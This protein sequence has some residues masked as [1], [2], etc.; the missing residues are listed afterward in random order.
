MEKMKIEISELTAEYPKLK[1]YVRKHPDFK[2]ERLT[3]K[4]GEN[5]KTEIYTLHY[6]T[7]YISFRIEETKKIIFQSIRRVKERKIGPI[8]LLGKFYFIR[9]YCK[10]KIKKDSILVLKNLKPNG[11]KF[12][13]KFLNLNKELEKSAD[14]IEK[15]KEIKFD[16]YIFNFKKIEK[17]VDKEWKKIKIDWEDISKE[18]PKL[19]KIIDKY[20]KKYPHLKDKLT[21]GL[22]QKGGKRTKYYSAGNKYISR[23]W[24]IR[25]GEITFT[26]INAEEIPKSGPL[27]ALSAIYY[28]SK[29][30]KDEIDEGKNVHIV[31]MLLTGRGFWSRFL[32]FKN[33]NK[34]IDYIKKN[35]KIKKGFGKVIDIELPFK[36]F[37]NLIN[38][39]W[40]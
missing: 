29:F 13:E 9:K 17:L 10:N 4:K 24:F 26:N 23:K 16:N 33:S 37:E 22:D 39:E 36:K 2:D 3:I 40:K 20:S 31:N 30:D 27:L 14:K 35:G 11:K 5:K 25:G 6:K 38:K 34:F 8:L 19:R 7:A 15:N 28:I 1:E 12:Y 32:G 21:I 18:Y